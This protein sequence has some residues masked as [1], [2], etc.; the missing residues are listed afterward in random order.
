MEAEI[1]L[2][3]LWAFGLIKDR[4]YFCF[5]KTDLLWAYSLFSFFCSYFL[6]WSISFMLCLIKYLPKI[7][8]GI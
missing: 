4:G 8:Y 2:A 7:S 5:Y 1:S 6:Y 3:D